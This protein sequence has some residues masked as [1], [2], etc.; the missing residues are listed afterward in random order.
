MHLGD[1]TCTICA[2]EYNLDD[3]VIVMQCDARH[4]FHE[5]CIKKWLSINANCPICRAP[6]ILE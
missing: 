3:K 1:P 6:Y 5:D 4:F 2:V